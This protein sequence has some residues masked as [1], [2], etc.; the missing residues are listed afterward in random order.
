MQLK[1]ANSSSHSLKS[2]NKCQNYCFIP[3]YHQVKRVFISEVP[4][5]K[6]YNSSPKYVAEFIQSV[7]QASPKK[8]VKIHLT[9]TEQGF[10]EVKKILF[11]QNSWLNEKNINGLIKVIKASNTDSI[12]PW[13]RDYFKFIHLDNQNHLTYLSIYD[14]VQEFKQG[15]ARSRFNAIKESLPN[16]KTHEVGLMTNKL[17]NNLVAVPMSGELTGLLGGNIEPFIEDSFMLG[18]RGLTENEWKSYSRNLCPKKNMAIKVDT[19]WLQVGHV[20][21]IIKVIKA[22]NNKP[23]GWTI[24]YPDTGLAMQLLNAKA[25]EHFI[26]YPNKILTACPSTNP[27]CMNHLDLIK[28][29]GFSKYLDRS[30][31]VP[32]KFNDKSKQLGLVPCDQLKY[33]FIE[34][35]LSYTTLRKYNTIIQE[36]I[37]TIVSDLKNKASTLQPQCKSFDFVPIPALYYNLDLLSQDIMY[38]ANSQEEQRY[39]AIQKKIDETTSGVIYKFKAS[40]VFPNVINNLQIENTLI[41]PYPYNQLLQKYFSENMTKRGFKVHSL[42]TL[43]F[44]HIGQGDVHC[45]TNAEAHCDL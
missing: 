4:A 40:N 41:A 44:G 8:L 13:Q 31:K 29:C 43:F 42:D 34:S 20:D 14:A 36:K 30:F 45:T 19:D 16:L 21:E 35:L 12:I 7:W 22:K 10:Q 1:A 28:L 6:A 25:N 37:N 27:K 15:T 26:D 11:K 24:L 32:E 38:I 18:T 17:Q 39:M 2:K 9:T 3:E 33:S 23:C 5:V